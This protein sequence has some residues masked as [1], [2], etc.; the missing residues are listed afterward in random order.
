MGVRIQTLYGNRVLVPRSGVGK[1]K[2]HKERSCKES[3]RVGSSGGYSPKGVGG[4]GWVRSLRVCGG[5]GCMALS[6][7][8]ASE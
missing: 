1:H 5:K 2:P 6:W 7:P 4:L 8:R 3:K